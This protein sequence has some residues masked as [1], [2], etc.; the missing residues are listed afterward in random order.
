M[1]F[2][3]FYR[4]GNEQV[5]RVSQEMGQV[6]GIRYLVRSETTGSTYS[7]AS[8]AGIPA[9]LTEAG[10]QGIWTAED[11][12]AARAGAGPA[13]AASRHDV[14]ARARAAA[15]HAARPLP[16]AA[17][18]GAARIL[19]SGNARSATRSA[20]A[21]SWGGC[22]TTRATCCRQRLRLRTAWCCSWSRRWRSTRATRSWRSV[23]SRMAR[24][25]LIRL[26]KGAELVRISD[27]N[28]MQV[29]AYLQHDDRAVLPLGS[30]EQHSYLSLSVDCILPER[31]AAR[32]GRAAG[33]PGVSGAGLRRHAVLPRASPARSRL[34]VETHLA[35]V[36]DILDSLARSG[37][38][39]ILIVNGHGG[40]SAAQSLARRMGGGSPRLPG[41]VPQLVERA[42]DLGRRCRR[43]T[44]WRRTARGWRISPGP[45]W[46]ASRCRQSRSPWSTWRGCACS[47]PP[48]LRGYLGDG[49]YG[50]LYQRPRRGHAGA[51]A[52]RRRGDARPA[53]R[54]RGGKH[55]AA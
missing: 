30:T 24:K 7:A 45:G 13:A 25:C 49:N 23:R 33:H 14:R 52:G 10:G 3:I 5:D 17:Q 18:R 2:T 28:W 16:V 36:R 47:I 4:S 29:E 55:E 54:R 15:L 41:E 12:G 48:A 9:I 11:V 35:V 51:L 50:G 32:G 38:R 8:R 27:M 39:R 6:F 43:S 22:S 34:R 46:P 19:V 20:R 42:A 31:V 1:P 44:R 53:G 26:R 37:F 21:R 40:N